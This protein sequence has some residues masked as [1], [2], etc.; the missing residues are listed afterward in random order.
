MK[1]VRVQRIQTYATSLRLESLLSKEE[2]EGILEGPHG[3]KAKVVR[4]L[5]SYD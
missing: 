3:I 4:P 1:E 2:I 5:L